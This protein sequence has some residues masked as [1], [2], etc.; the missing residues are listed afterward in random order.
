[1][2]TST[3]TPQTTLV[4]LSHL[5]TIRKEPLKTLKQFLWLEIKG[6]Y[7]KKNT[8]LGLF[9]KIYAWFRAWILLC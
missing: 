5:T 4:A 7:V 9:I 6:R 8:V 3:L 2:E 1:M